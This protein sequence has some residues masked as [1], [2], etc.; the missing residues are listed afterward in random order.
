MKSKTIELKIERL[1]KQKINYEEIIDTTIQKITKLNK[2]YQ[3]VLITLDSHKEPTTPKISKELSDFD[4]KID[5]AEQKVADYELKIKNID[6]TL[7]ELEKDL[8]QA[9]SEEA[10]VKTLEKR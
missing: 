7:K 5:K 3:T 1:K 8:I 6:D 2:S 4:V 10:N 9:V